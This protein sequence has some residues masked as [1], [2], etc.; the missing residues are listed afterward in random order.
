MRQRSLSRQ[1][2]FG[3]ATEL[4]FILA[5]GGAVVLGGHAQAQDVTWTGAVDRL[6]FMGSSF[7]GESS[8]F[9]GVISDGATNTTRLSIGANSALTLTGNNTSSGTATI[10]EGMLRVG[11]CGTTGTLGSA[12]VV[13]N[14]ALVVNR[15]NALTGV[16]TLT[17]SNSYTGPTTVQNG[18]LALDGGAAINH[19]GAVTVERDAILQVLASERIGTLTLSGETGN[20]GTILTVSGDYSAT[21][22]LVLDVVPGGDGSA[23]DRLVVADWSGTLI[24]GQEGLGRMASVEIGQKFM[25]DN[26]LT[27]TPQAQ[28]GWSDVRIDSFTTE[29][30]A[31]IDVEESESLRLRLGLAGKKAWATGPGSRVYGIANLIHGFDRDSRVLIDGTALEA[32]TA[33]WTAEVGF[34]GT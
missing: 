30:G 11:A 32:T 2:R 28:R 29:S 4:I 33:C 7:I 17:G 18:T 1:F 13:N 9:G 21:S 16:T 31:A 26:G 15:S 24:A 34:G 12:A 22:D 20:A 23:S 27:W 25:Q 6:L 3:R 10:S 14:A 5:A 19:A 8:T